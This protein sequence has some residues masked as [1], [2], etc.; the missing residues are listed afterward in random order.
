MGTRLNRENLAVGFAGPAHANEP[1]SGKE[2]KLKVSNIDGT[3]PAKAPFLLTLEDGTDR[4]EVV[5]VT[6]VSEGSFTVVRGQEGTE[7]VDHPT[8]C[9]F[10]FGITNQELA[11]LVGAL[12]SKK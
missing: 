3:L 5:K 2:T 12:V 11:D 6:S 8:P 9:T 7:A 1:I 10:N 4:Y